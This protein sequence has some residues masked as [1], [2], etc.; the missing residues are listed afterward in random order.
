MN[1]T[2]I[3]FSIVL[4]IFGILF[5]FTKLY[6]FFPFWKKMEPKERAKMNMKAISIN[7]GCMVIACS[8]ILLAAGLWEFFYDKI[9]IWA[10]IIW[11]VAIVMDA[12]L[13]ST[14]KLY[15]REETKKGQEHAKQK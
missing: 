7:I 2:C 14:K 11:G 5:F 4:F 6:R 15:Y 1:I 10:M 12:I 13:I 8:L 9:F 3:A